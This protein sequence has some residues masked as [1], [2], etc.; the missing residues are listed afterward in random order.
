MRAALFARRR[1]IRFMKAGIYM[2]YA[3]SIWLA[4]ALTACAT[5]P[6]DAPAGTAYQNMQFLT[7]QKLMSCPLMRY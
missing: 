5:T 2:R 7:L 4:L 3:N 6:K 1:E